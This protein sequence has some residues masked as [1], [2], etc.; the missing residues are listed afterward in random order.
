MVPPGKR[1]CITFQGQKISTFGSLSEEPLT[2]VHFLA[3]L[4]LTK[5]LQ[6][7][8]KFVARDEYH[9]PLTQSRFGGT[10]FLYPLAAPGNTEYSSKALPWLV[11]HAFS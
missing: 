10:P 5:S 7:L 2:F 8:R 3:I 4:S 6:R 1:H 9:A 11:S